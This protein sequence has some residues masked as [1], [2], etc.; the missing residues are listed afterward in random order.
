M[1]SKEL[2]YAALEGRKPERA[3]RQMWTLPWAEKAYPAEMA[4]IRSQFPA[5]IG[6]VPATLKTPPKTQGDMYAKGTYV[7]EWGCVFTNVHEGIIGEVK[8]PIVPEEDEDWATADKIHIP[9]EMLSFDVDEVNRGC[10]QR[11]QFLVSG[12]TP[13]PF[14]QL[15]FIRGTENLYMDL[16]D[17]PKGMLDFMDKM[18]AFYCELLEKWAKTDVDALNMMDDWG[19]QRSLLISP[20]LW[21]RYFYPMY[22]DYIDI[23]HSHGKKMFM[24]SDGCILDILPY[25]IEAGLDAVNSQIFCMGLDKVARF[26]G[27]ITFWGEMDRQHLLPHGTEAEVRQAVRQVYD[28]LWDNGHCIAQLEF[29][30]GAKPENVA[31]VFDEWNKITENE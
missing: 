18:H 1:T 26:K 12:Y 4:Q 5:D 22:K 23:A 14:E 3:P 20:A 19:A 15:Q 6:G 2:V 27:Q 28:A 29:G 7:D 8:Q 31:A 17:P 24:H 11:E 25:L 30:P 13:H 16:M 9:Y 10:A 21:K